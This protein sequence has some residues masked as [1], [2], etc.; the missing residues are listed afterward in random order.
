MIVLRGVEEEA[1]KVFNP[2][3][4]TVPIEEVNRVWIL[5]CAD[6]IGAALSTVV[7]E[8]IKIDVD[9]DD[10][11]DAGYTVWLDWVDDLIESVFGEVRVVFGRS[12]NMVIC[13]MQ[14]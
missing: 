9:V 5:F 7:G 13:W 2:G 8:R 6:V 4:M 3:I 11:L 1:G 10:V 12:I 14:C